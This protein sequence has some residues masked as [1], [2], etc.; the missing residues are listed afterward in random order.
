MSYASSSTGLR[1]SANTALVPYHNTITNRIQRFA[2]THPKTS[3]CVVFAATKTASV[4]SSYFV[5]I[6]MVMYAFMGVSLMVVLGGLCIGKF[7]G[8]PVSRTLRHMKFIA[9]SPFSLMIP[10][11]HV[12]STHVFKTL[13]YQAPGSAHDGNCS[14]NYE[15]HVPVLTLIGDP[16]SCGFAHG[17][18][19]ADHIHSLIKTWDSILW[20]VI[21]APS[22]AA[23]LCKHLENLIPEHIVIEM[24]ALVR[25]YNREIYE[26]GLGEQL[27]FEKL[28]LLHLVPDIEHTYPNMLARTAVGCT[29]ILD[30]GDEDTGP[31]FGRHMD[32]PSLDGGNGGAGE[33]T[34][35]IRRVMPNGRII[36]EIGTPGLVGGVVTGMSNDGLALAMLV[37]LGK[38]Q[39]SKTGL[40]AIV[41]NRMVLERCSTVADALK[42]IQALNPLG[43]YHLTL[44]D[45]SGDASAVHF[46]QSAERGKHF[47]RSLNERVD[48]LVVTN[49]S[50]NENGRYAPY[51]NSEKRHEN[52]EMV[53]GRFSHNPMGNRRKIVK[54]ALKTP[55]VN[56]IETAFSGIM[57]PKSGRMKVSF[58]NAYAAYEP[59]H[60]VRFPQP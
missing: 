28:L 8:H 33:K 22:K 52:I 47:I 40:P 50:Y 30:R 4:A 55:L 51:F 6:A 27:T 15:G 48:H 49:C 24:K 25:G 18:L 3:K 56:N 42:Y 53:Y 23:K 12:M 58:G 39:N 7:N 41:L 13:Q 35:V 1:Y 31:I 17:V 10:S 34:L 19:L 46:Y 57:E 54:K 32:W 37:A 14:L 43:P 45:K 21:P 29:V 26:K 36:H 11:R 60:A 9:A 59:R 44:A 20:L 16:E 2:Y 5:G 38:T